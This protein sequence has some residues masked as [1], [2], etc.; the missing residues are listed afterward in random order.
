MLNIGCGDKPTGDVNLDRF[1]YGK[2]KNFFIADAH[3]LPFKD[4]GFEKI[5]AKSC[6]EHFNKPNDFFKEA[7]RVLKNGGI[8]EC[9]YPTESR[10]IKITLHNL[11]NLRWSS[12]FRWKSV[13]I[14]A[15]KI[16]H[17]GH[18][19]QLSDK[20]L[21]SLLLKSG[22]TRITFYKIS[23]PT[24]RITLNSKENGLKFLINKYLPL[25]Q[26]DTK[27]IAQLP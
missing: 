18:K 1:Y 13:L 25:W 26:L 15:N 9:V 11:L 20:G 3:Y 27:F 12:A 21:K 4:N 16:T 7:K 5:Y 23:F 2:G 19:W 6:L 24:L 8:L 22:F 14:G 17:G 10:Y